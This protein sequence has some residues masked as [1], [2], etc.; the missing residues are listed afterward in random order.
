MA[1]KR[2]GPKKKRAVRPKTKPAKV[3]NDLKPREKSKD[4]KGGL[5]CIPIIAVLIGLLVPSEPTPNPPPPPPPPPP[6]LRRSI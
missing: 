4:V 2:P 1:K 3:L 5:V 6:K